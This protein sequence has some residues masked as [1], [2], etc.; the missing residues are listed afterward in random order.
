MVDIVVAFWGMER[1]FAGKLEGKRGIS[2]K[3]AKDF[4]LSAQ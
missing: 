2:N 1:G 3:L 4:I